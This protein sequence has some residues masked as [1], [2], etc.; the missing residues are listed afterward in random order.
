MH[1]SITRKG[2]GV[3]RGP[4]L[5]GLTQHACDL[6]AL[7]DPRLSLVQARQFLP[8]ESLQNALYALRELEL[9]EGPPVALRTPKPGGFMSPGA[10]AASAST[11]P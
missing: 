10:G 8:P 5:W 4:A 3:L 11:L 9:I 7:C 6:L 1:Y 2:L